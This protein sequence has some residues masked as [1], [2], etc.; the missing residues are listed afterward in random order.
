[1]TPVEKSGQVIVV[2]GN[3]QAEDIARNMSHVTALQ[4]GSDIHTIALHKTPAVTPEQTAVLQRANHVLA[5]NIAEFAT[6]GIEAV[7][8]EHAKLSRF[9][10]LPLRS[11]WPFD[12]FMFG[13][14]ELAQADI[15]AGGVVRFGDGLLGALRKAI[16]DPEARFQAY[17][18]L[19]VPMPLAP[20]E[21]LFEVEAAGLL[22]LDRTFD[23][24][25]GQHIVAHAKERRLFHWIGHANADVY[26]LL[27]SLCLRHIGIGES[28][29][30]T[31]LLD[32]WSTIQAPIHPEVVRRLGLTWLDPEQ[33]YHYAP[34]GHITWETYI[35]TYIAHLG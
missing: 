32:A 20:I 21:R 13:R 15:A 16:P 24:N 10:Y 30:P 8:S 22:S 19:D 18:S 7:I 35:R 17:R 31:G 23:M 28:A 6:S 25:I 14:D 11:L 9:P 29:M 1:V 34:I 5:Q 33:I 3:C 26:W 12:T 27:T 4:D 2:V